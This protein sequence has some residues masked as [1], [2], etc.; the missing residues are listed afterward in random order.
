MDRFRQVQAGVDNGGSFGLITGRLDA[1]SSHGSPAG[2]L[3]TRQGR[4]ART[5]LV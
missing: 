2:L 4:S 5:N 3:T 1:T